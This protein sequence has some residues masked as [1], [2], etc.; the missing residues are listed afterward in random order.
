MPISMPNLARVLINDGRASRNDAEILTRVVEAG[1]ATREELDSAKDV[2]EKSDLPLAKKKYALRQLESF[3][4][5]T[6]TGIESALFGVDPRI[7]NKLRFA[8]I[9]SPARL[10]KKAATPAQRE[11]LARRV[12]DVDERTI[13]TLAKQADL[14]RVTGIDDKTAKVL[15]DL[16]IDSVPEL[17]GRNASNLFDKLKAFSA[18][19]EAWIIKFKLPTA[20]DVA[21]W[22]SQAQG[23]D[24]KLS[25]GR[26]S[27]GW[28]ALTTA[29]RTDMFMA[30]DA[31][32][33]ASWPSGETTSVLKELGLPDRAL[34]ALENVT[35]DAADFIANTLGYR[36]IDADPDEIADGT[37]TSSDIPSGLPFDFDI[38][39]S[40][41]AFT[42]R[43]GKFL[44]AKLTWSVYDDPGQVS[45][46]AIYDAVAGRFTDTIEFD[47]Y[48]NEET[49]RGEYDVTSDRSGSATSARA[50]KLG[51]LVDG[52]VYISESDEP[53]SAV[54]FE[55]DRGSLDAA[56]FRE[57]VLGGR[58]DLEVDVRDADATSDFWDYYT[59]DQIHSD[60]DV[61]KFA[62]LKKY[63]DANLGDVRIVKTGAPGAA[64]RTFWLLGT[65]DSGALV[66]LRAKAVET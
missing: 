39:P 48:N 45:F 18:T 60:A 25:F 22:K 49:Y 9:D 17:A 34:D 13:R 14:Q 40:I 29:E 1:E 41:T 62:T 51:E 15:V 55:F 63:V 32:L 31:S 54:A 4:D 58:T 3:L 11:A 38:D 52:L 33:T 21:S 66:G 43:S 61:K 23:L 47:H 64:E 46:N 35:L 6:A 65:D 42:D 2:I 53:F 16:G 44:G 20:D 8:G 7:A 36:G 30:E 10:L 5:D 12:G 19:Q 26:V 56:S 28:D 50:A 57:A 37:F 59:D 27:S 24:R